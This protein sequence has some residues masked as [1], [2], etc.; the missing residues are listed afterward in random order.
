[1]PE[2][3]SCSVVAIED[4]AGLRGPLTKLVEVIAAGMGNLYRPMGIVREGDAEAKRIRALASAGADAIRTLAAA[5]ADGER[6]MDKL[7][8]ERQVARLEFVPDMAK[9]A[10]MRSAAEAI[11]QQEN[12]ERIAASAAQAMADSVS[13]EPVSADWR[14]LFFSHARDVSDHMMRGVWGQVLAGEVAKPGSYSMR[15]LELLRL[16]SRAEAEAFARFCNLVFEPDYV[17]RMDGGLDEFGVSFA[18]ILALQGAGMLFETFSISKSFPKKGAQVPAK[19]LLVTHDV[20]LQLSL[21]RR[22][23]AS[24]YMLTRAGRELRRLVSSQANPAYIEAVRKDLTMPGVALEPFPIRREGE[25][26]VFGK[27][28]IAPEDL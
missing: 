8:R 4:L 10:E 22:F 17:V 7:E 27:Q 11:A 24:V 23:E 19:C 14:T 3:K 13:E 12:L 21:H 5:Q 6:E 9:R 15:T 26:I 25:L 20:G 28:R 2:E 1:M 16:M 18:D